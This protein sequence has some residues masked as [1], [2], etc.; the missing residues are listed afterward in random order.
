MIIRFKKGLFVEPLTF[1]EFIAVISIS[2][3]GLLS[4]ILAYM[5]LEFRKMIRTLAGSVMYGMHGTEKRFDDIF[6]NYL[7]EHSKDKYVR[8]LAWRVLRGDSMVWHLRNKHAY[9]VAEMEKEPA[10][11]KSEIK[12]IENLLGSRE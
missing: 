11:F 8:T 2:T 12:D 1:G 9:V 5:Y 7:I 4:C 3:V 6:K 10:D